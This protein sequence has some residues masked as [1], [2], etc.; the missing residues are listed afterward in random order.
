MKEK[1]NAP[2][3]CGSG[4]KYKKCCGGNFI[5]VTKPATRECGDC[6]AC[7]QGWLTTHALGNDIFVDHPC[8]HT[9]GHGCT[10]HADRPNDPCKLFFCAWV[11]SG[12]D[13]PGWMHPGLSGVIVL[14]NR[15]NWRKTPVD[16]LVS[17]YKDPDD[18]VIQ[19]FQSRS[20]SQSRPFIYQQQNQWFG[21]G[22]QAFLIDIA[23][24][25][26]SGQA[27]WDGALLG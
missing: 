27:L 21:F 14:E 1:R 4:L 9:D 16:I 5:D 6:A 12:S 17:T 3:A 10:I 25:T 7:C 22:P 19:W 8:P 23:E 20:K 24:K 11:E 15:M 18:R 13:L 26:A 2:C